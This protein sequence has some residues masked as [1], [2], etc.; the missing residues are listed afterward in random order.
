M[1]ERKARRQDVRASTKLD[2][3]PAP[4]ST[5]EVRPS[6]GSATWI[7]AGLCVI[8]VAIYAGVMH[9]EFI[10]L[11]DAAYIYL[12]PH[13]SAGFN[14]HS[15]VWA[16]RSGYP[17]YWHPLTW[18]SHMLDVR[19]FGM[20]AGA[21][22]AVSLLLHMLSTLLLFGALHWM[23]GK[24]GRS[25]F[26]AALF[27]A[28][29][30]HVESV[31]WAAERKD[32]LS[33]F[34][35]MSTL[36]AYAWYVRRPR[37]V[38]YTAVA[39]L[40]GLGLMSK[41]MLVTLPFTLLLLDYWPLGRVAAGGGFRDA[42][43]KL[44]L[45]KLPLFALSAAASV[46][47]FLVTRNE[48]AMSGLAAIPPLSRIAHATVAYGVYLSK[49][50]WPANLAPFY[51]YQTSPPVWTVVASAV[52]LIGISTLVV[53]A[54]RARPY[55]VV[56]WFWY[57]GTLVP[58]I[59][60]VQ[61]GDQA[62]ADRFMYVPLIGLAIIASWGG[63]DV[64]ARVSLSKAA[65]AAA[66]A[67]VVA[68]VVVARTQVAYWQDSYSTWTHALAVTVN[69]PVAENSL[70]TV[71]SDQGRLDEAVA[72]LTKAVGIEPRSLDARI[73]LGLALS[74]Q[75]RFGDAV[76]QDRAAVQL[77]PGFAL[78]H[79]NL[80]LALIR[81]GPSSEA[82][83]ELNEALRLDPGNREAREGLNYLAKAHK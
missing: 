65:P 13:V 64:L 63:F 16:F 15:V 28:H 24:L 56:G 54:S 51:P 6:P 47:T 30:L 62:W 61:V 57:L 23:T 76:V 10:D 81:T 50:L 9:H 58:V 69:N 44:M 52:V 39:A 46:I 33:T 53:R 67:I 49:T 25:A 17:S 70:G 83:H 8:N 18:F 71:L 3:R 72:H 20:N 11:D 12:N 80:G 68:L 31:A 38:R 73:N 82:V 2:G 79:C 19:L 43:P 42:G 60:L 26:V 78:A 35:W 66:V 36:C 37:V 55:L 75:G 32:V 77:N 40:F 1:R 4:S 59:G 27:A 7:A 41:P 22:H 5:P 29:P 34:F 21:H 45:E 48:G 14:W 74:R